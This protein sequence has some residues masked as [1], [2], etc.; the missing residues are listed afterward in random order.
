MNGSDLIALRQIAP[1]NVV[2]PGQSSH[3]LPRSA[4]FLARLSGSIADRL[5]RRA[6]HFPILPLAPEQLQGVLLISQ[7]SPGRIVVN[8]IQAEPQVVGPN[9]YLLPPSFFNHHENI[10]AVR[11][12]AGE[13]SLAP[14]LDPSR[15][16]SLPF[17]A[18]S[19]SVETLDGRPLEPIPVEPLPATTRKQERIHALALALRRFVITEG[20]NAGDVWSFYDLADHGFRLSQWRWDSA[21]VLEAL[22]AAATATGDD[23]L[24]ET[25]VAVGDRFLALE[26]TEEA[27]LGGTPEWVDLRYTEKVDTITQWVAPFNEG[28]VAAGLARLYLASREKRFLEAARRSAHL[29]ATRGITAVGGLYGYYFLESGTWRYLGQINDSGIMPRGLAAVAAITGRTFHAGAALLSMRF[30]IELA[31]TDAG[32]FLRAWWR[33]SGAA[34]TGQPLFPEWKRH[35]RRVVQKIFLRGQA[36]VLLGLASTLRMAKAP[37]LLERAANLAAHL[38]TVQDSG[39]GWLYS[40][41]QPEMGLCV[42]GTAAIALALC[43]YAAVTGDR[44]PLSSVRKALVFLDA[45][46]NVPETPAELAP[47]PVDRSAEGCII[48]FRNRPVVCA[49]AGALEILAR[50]ALADLEEQ[51]S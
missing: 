44:T 32:P 27:C 48:Y 22:A 30:L 39:G 40:G 14:V 9:R 13:I 46:S 8:G 38:C 28:F 16:N 42:K 23:S 45:A 17:R 25:A 36:W 41:H 26:V 20:N 43:E 24:L 29:A 3:T 15:K 4:G 47:L 12:A 2:A 6:L 49:Y 10:V 50:M 35:P 1:G 5:G 19:W 34:L 11:Q 21:I 37:D 7:A 31:G 18:P 51:A 33:P